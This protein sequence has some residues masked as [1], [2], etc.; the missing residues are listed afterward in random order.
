MESGLIA[1]EAVNWSGGGQ[2]KE[3][4][5]VWDI[6]SLTTAASNFPELCAMTPQRK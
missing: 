2:I 5:A 4:D 6:D 3:I 1:R